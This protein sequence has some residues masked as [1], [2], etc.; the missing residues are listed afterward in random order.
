ME[1][2]DDMTESVSDMQ[3]SLFIT[4]ARIYDVLLALLTETNKEVAKDLLELHASGMLMGPVPAFNGTF[5][6]S[7]VNDEEDSPTDGIDTA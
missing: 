1:E 6:T 5:I 4:Q 3:M 2:E 7:E